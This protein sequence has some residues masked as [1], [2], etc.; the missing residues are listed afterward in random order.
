MMVILL[1]L[2]FMHMDTYFYE[3]ILTY[4]CEFRIDIKI[5]MN[6]NIFLIIDM[7]MNINANINSDG[8]CIWMFLSI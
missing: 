3:N 2:M 7:N 6:I 5:N 4:K 1:I 8:I